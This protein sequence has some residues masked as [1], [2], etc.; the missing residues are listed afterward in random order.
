MDAGIRFF[1]PTPS[2]QKWTYKTPLITKG[3]EAGYIPPSLF[4][5]VDLVTAKKNL[6][7]GDPKPIHQEGWVGFDEVDLHPD[8]KRKTYLQPTKGITGFVL[9]EAFTSVDTG[10]RLEDVPGLKDE[11][12]RVL[13]T[14]L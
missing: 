12:M 14:N 6:L 1:S 4:S 10:L 7:W 5:R 2:T 11:A 8:G 13:Q 3:N 9:P